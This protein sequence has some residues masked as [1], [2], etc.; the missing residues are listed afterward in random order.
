MKTE[1]VSV[2]QLSRSILKARIV[3][4][5]EDYVTLELQFEFEEKQEKIITTDTF[6]GYEGLDDWV[7][8]NYYLIEKIN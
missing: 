1:N 6:G 5:D 4:R 7:A 2:Y 3:S 8:K